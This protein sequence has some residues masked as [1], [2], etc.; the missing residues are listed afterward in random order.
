VVNYL[1][2]PRSAETPIPSG[3]DRAWR[4]SSRCAIGRALPPAPRGW[5]THR[6]CKARSPSMP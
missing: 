3:R 1:L 2:D 5:P 6:R 4:F